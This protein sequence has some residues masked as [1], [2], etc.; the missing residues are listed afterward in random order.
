MET[1]KKDF[2]KSIVVSAIIAIVG[3]TLI[4][5]FFVWFYRDIPAELTISWFSFWGVEL[6][7]LAGIRIK[8]V[9]HFPYLDDKGDGQQTWNQS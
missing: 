3:Y 7:Y 1:K 8:E 4:H 5:L 2:S 6:G 9:N